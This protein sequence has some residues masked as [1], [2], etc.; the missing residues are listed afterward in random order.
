[1]GS[2]MF[3]AR[4]IIDNFNRP[5]EQFNYLF[6]YL[7]IIHKAIY[8]SLKMLSKY[9]KVGFFFE[10]SSSKGIQLCNKNLNLMDG[11]RTIIFKILKLLPCHSTWAAIIECKKCKDLGFHV[12]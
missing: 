1:L 9:I 11:L 6:S 2:W 4:S 7:S 8:L 12:I 10:I 3:I 5:V